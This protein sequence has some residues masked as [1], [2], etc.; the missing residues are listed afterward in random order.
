MGKP[1]SGQACPLV[2]AE[3]NVATGGEAGE[4][5]S[6]MS[7]INKELVLRMF[8]GFNARDRATIE[9]VYAPDCS[10]TTPDGPLQGGAE[11]LA[12]FEKYWLS[13]PDCRL[14][15]NFLAADG[16]VVAAHYTFVG[17]S[18]NSLAGLPATGRRMSIPSALFSRI[19]GSQIVEQYFIWDNLGPRRQEWLASTVE[20][21][22]QGT[23]S[24]W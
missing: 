12:F 6:F 5:E 18:T 4:K 21:Q 10:G 9:N 17:T 13:F 7:P 14:H 15:I 11:Y 8:D 23:Q 24:V 3:E 2:S 19:K 16:E 1:W 20:K 22:F